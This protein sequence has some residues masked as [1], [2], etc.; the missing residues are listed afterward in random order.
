MKR[1]K[2][3]VKWFNRKKNYGF[4]LGEDNK[5]YF[6]HGSQ[7]E[8]NDPIKADSKVE[9]EPKESDKGLSANRVILIGEE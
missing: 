8:N 5:E 6:F 4:I 2:G 3:N 9:F 7:I 1:I